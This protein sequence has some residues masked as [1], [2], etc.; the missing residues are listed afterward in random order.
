[1]SSIYSSFMYIN[2]YI[3]IDTFTIIK[4]QQRLAILPLLK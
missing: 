3:F 4:H 2:K 1:M